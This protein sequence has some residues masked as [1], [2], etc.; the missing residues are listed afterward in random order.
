MQCNSH[1]WGPGNIS[2]DGAE[3]SQEP[4]DQDVRFETAPSMYVWEAEF[5]KLQ[6][7][8]CLDKT[9]KMTDMPAWTG[10]SSQGSTPQ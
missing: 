10:E 5:M 4:K 1:I 7:R 2:E 6:Q 3:K 9:W 8:G